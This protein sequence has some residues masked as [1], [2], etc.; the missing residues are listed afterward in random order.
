[1]LFSNLPHDILRYEIRS[2]LDDISLLCLRV[3]LHLDN[4]GDILR[5]DL[6]R[7]AISHDS[8]FIQYFIDKG[9][10]KG[11][12]LLS[13]CAEAGNL[14][15]LQYFHKQNKY[16]WDAGVANAVITYNH[17]DCLGYA[18]SYDTQG[19]GRRMAYLA[20]TNGSLE[21]MIY[22][23][24]RRGITWNVD[25]FRTAVKYGHVHCVRYLFDKIDI[26]DFRRT[27]E[28]IVLGTYY[29]SGGSSDQLLTIHT[30]GLSLDWAVPYA[31]EKN[32][33]DILDFLATL[34]YK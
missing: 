29:G 15:K 14:S 16:H 4:F 5:F 27:I 17:V 12:K 28:L 26:N 24:Q 18:L 8:N 21:C 10:I 1:M 13:F 33:Q 11:S 7:Q 3:A 2:R 32:K 6:Q 20:I 25:S 9:L 31:A 22:L 23:E 19:S 30:A 34:G